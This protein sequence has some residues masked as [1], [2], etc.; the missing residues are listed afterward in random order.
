MAD[1]DMKK[2]TLEP[3]SAT[4]KKTFFTS[5]IQWHMTLD[6]CVFLAYVVPLFQKKFEEADADL[7]WLTLYVVKCSEF[8]KGYWLFVLVAQLVVYAVLFF[9]LRRYSKRFLSWVWFTAVIILQGALIA[10]CFYAISLPA[11]S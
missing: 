1:Y 2:E 9:F 7:P 8:V 10:L 11:A 5:L 6:L 3:L 4:V